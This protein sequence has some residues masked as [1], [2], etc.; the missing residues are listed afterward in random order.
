MSFVVR[1][2]CEQGLPHW[3]PLLLPQE[4]L[5]CRSCCSGRLLR[6]KEQKEEEGN[7]SYLSRR[8]GS[9]NRMRKRKNDF[10]ADRNKGRRKKWCG[11]YRAD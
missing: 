5:F 4:I 8:A 2:Q 11:R 7:V 1:G 3:W 10:D 6:K 9:E